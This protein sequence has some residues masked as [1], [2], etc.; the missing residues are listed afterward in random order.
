MIKNTL[1]AALIVSLPVQAQ[2]ATQP[3]SIPATPQH[4]HWEA[5]GVMPGRNMSAEERAAVRE[6][7]RRRILERFDTDKDGQLSEEERA[8]ARDQMGSRRPH[9]ERAHRPQGPAG[10]AHPGNRRRPHS[11]RPEMIQRFD[12]DGNGELN[13]AEREALRTAVQ[14]RRRER[15]QRSPRRLQRPE[16]QQ[17]MPQPTAADTPTTLEL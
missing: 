11:E 5:D 8:A 3:E 14:N 9:G 10:N 17:P 7:V 1:I 2:E 12:T 13:E 4:R 15:A 6:N 16:D